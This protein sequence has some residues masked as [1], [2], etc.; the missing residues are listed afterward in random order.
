MNES[1]EFS[2]HS[3]QE[4]EEKYT[5][6]VLMALKGGKDIKA[7]LSIGRVIGQGESS[8]VKEG[9]LKFNKGDRERI[10]PI[11]FK[12][13]RSQ[14]EGRKEES[15]AAI[16]IR[17]NAYKAQLMYYEILRRLGV[18]VIP[19][20]RVAHDNDNNALGIVMTNLEVMPLDGKSEVVNVD[21]TKT[22]SWG[23]EAT[24][25]SRKKD[26]RLAGKAGLGLHRDSWMLQYS[27]RWKN[28]GRIL[29]KAVVSDVIGVRIDNSNKFRQF[30]TKNPD[31]FEQARE[32]NY[33]ISYL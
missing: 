11:A 5:P 27:T 9:G 31:L 22:D 8:V 12:A 1:G 18:N 30:L 10:Y 6:V 17:N 32:N 16:Y 29:P 3:E 21:T 23:H 7:D 24:S 13:Y 33:F 25:L 2:E 14:A 28:L 4:R 20:F 26:R 15:D 19:T